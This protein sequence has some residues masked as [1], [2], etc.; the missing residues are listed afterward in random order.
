MLMEEGGGNN[1]EVDV[2]EGNMR[3]G[4]LCG[5]RSEAREVT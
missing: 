4:K 2:R 3:D 1:R 5:S